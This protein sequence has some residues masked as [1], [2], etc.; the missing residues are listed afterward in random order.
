M[1]DAH[2]EIS[3]YLAIHRDITERKRAQE[4]LREASTRADEILESI[5]DEFI[6]FDARWG[7]TY[8]N[9]SALRAINNALGTQ[10]TNAEVLG[11]AV[12]DLFPEFVNTT[13][14]AELEQARVGC[15]AAQVESYTDPDDRWVEVRAYPSKDAGLT[16]YTREVTERRRVE[17]RLFEARELVPSAGGELA[18]TPGSGINPRSP[19]FQSAQHACAKLQ[20]GGDARPV[21]TE[22]QK[23]AAIAF[24]KCMRRHGLPD[25]PDVTAPGSG[26]I[27]R[28]GP[29]FGLRCRCVGVARGRGVGGEPRW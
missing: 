10:L 28:R 9:Q 7:Y 16:A 13:L 19:G 4:G 25:F 26:S 20:P 24:A 15:R 29:G 22:S 12:G 21:P 3:G 23:L 6:C 17:A 18:I 8:V 14:H 2:G 5:T 11:K 1:R 27:V